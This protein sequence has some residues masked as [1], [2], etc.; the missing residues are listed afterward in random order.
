MRGLRRR[1]QWGG[2]MRRRIVRRVG[3]VGSP[4]IVGRLVSWQRERRHTHAGRAGEQPGIQRQR[5]ACR[6]KWKSTQPHTRTARG[7]LSG[8]WRG[9]G[10][11]RR[12]ERRRGAPA[13]ASAS[14]CQ[15]AN[16]TSASARAGEGPY[17]LRCRSHRIA[18]IAAGGAAAKGRQAVCGGAAAAAAARRLLAATVRAAFATRRGALGLGGASGVSGGPP[19]RRPARPCCRRPSSPGR[20]AQP[21]LAV[22]CVAGRH[23]RGRA[24]TRPARLHPPAVPLP[25]STALRWR[26]RLCR[27]HRPR[28]HGVGRQRPLDGPAAAAAAAAGATRRGRPPARRNH[29]RRQR[30]RRGRRLPGARPSAAPMP[31]PLLVASAL[32]RRAPSPSAS[33]WTQ[34][35][36]RRRTA[37]MAWPG[38]AAPPRPVSQ[39]AKGSLSAMVSNQP[40]VA[41]S[42]MFMNPPPG[43]PVALQ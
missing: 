7:L 30:R 42:G 9:R 38:W 35:M 33:T 24:P 4:A 40:A 12:V 2:Q 1:Q 15:R 23:C 34:R 32:L 22:W 5:S 13:P 3:A 26:P 14:H 31:A 37:S 6:R 43:V 10:S 27:Q 39:H 17:V 16:A 18:T 28:Q 41:L 29:R 11:R 20:A 36:G 19:A 25:C 8:M 21:Y